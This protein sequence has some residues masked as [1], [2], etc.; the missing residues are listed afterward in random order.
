MHYFY[1][2]H[3]LFIITEMGLAAVMVEDPNG[4]NYS[5]SYRVNFI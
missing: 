1:Q 2:A 4:E 5:Y 3:K